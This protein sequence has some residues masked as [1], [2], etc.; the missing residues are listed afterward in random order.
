MEDDNSEPNSS[1]EDDYYAFLNVSRNAPTDEITNAYRRLS[2]LYHPDKHVDPASKREAEIIFNKTK[3]AYEVLKDPHKRAIYDSVG[4]KGLETDGWEV[5]QRSKT[6]QEIREEYEQ[7][8]RQREERRLQQRTNPK[9][10]ITININAT[11]LFNRY[12]YDLDYDMPNSYPVIEVSGM[13][14][15][16]SIEAPL[17]ARNTSS[18]SGHLSTH[19]GTGQGT[20]NLTNRYTLSEKSWVELG[21]GAGAG[22]LLIFKAFRTLYKRTFAQMDT[23]VL[24]GSNGIRTGIDA[25]TGINLDSGTMG[26]L[27]WRTGS[28]SSM[29]TSFVKDTETYNTNVSV[30]F[31]VPHSHLLFA[32]AWKRKEA[33]MKLRTSLKIGTAGLTFEYGAEKK[34]SEQSTVAA[35][36][37]V[38]VPTGVIL[39]LRLT[40]ASQ[41]FIFPVQLC[42]EPLP[43]PV[44]YGTV[45]PLVVY[46]VVKRFIVD[47]IVNEQAQ[48][49][50]KRQKD[51]YRSRMAEKRK[52][53]V[54]AVNLMSVAFARIRSEEE[55]RRGLVI[56]SALYGKLTS[57]GDPGS[58]LSDEVIDVTIPI[59]CLVKD[60]KLVIYESTKSQLPG[61]YDPCVGEDKFLYIQYLFHS[62]LHQTTIQDNEPLRIPRQSHRVVA[63]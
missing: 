18:I 61:F 48:A 7:L 62:Q 30:V 14:I 10:N 3:K 34:V 15:N 20:I 24:F 53:A 11:D 22:P 12:G 31:G 33:K 45:V 55:S 21:G 28:S 5:M 63:T 51:T 19:N 27:T 54:A 49:E 36:M 16:Q 46:A 26:Y 6:P 23:F 8:A 25:T 29:T 41:T 13:A 2:R 17:T 1:L 39:K 57:H 60:S 38:G 42:D 35:A 40:R 50:K 43:S 59:Q 52:E 47:P 44:F 56:I 4:I 32:F 9:G 37:A 58:D